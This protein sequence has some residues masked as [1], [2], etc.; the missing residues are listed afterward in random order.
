MIKELV[1]VLGCE[2]ERIFV[3]MTRRPDE[4]KTRTSS[5]RNKFEELYKKVKDETTDWMQVIANAEEDGKIRSKKMYLYLTQKGRCMYT[6]KHIELDD[7]F[8]NNLYDIDHIY[9]R[10]FVKDD[11]IDN[12]LVLVCKEKNAHKSDHL[13]ALLIQKDVKPLQQLPNLPLV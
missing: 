10:H 13:R 12:N 6:G 3:E 5:R 4:H 9:P 2:P 1:K 8:D 11:N 7:L